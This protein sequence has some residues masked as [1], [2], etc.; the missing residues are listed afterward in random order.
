MVGVLLFIDEP[1]ASIKDSTNDF[2]T[3]GGSMS[4]LIIDPKELSIDDNTDGSI[5]AALIIGD[6]TGNDDDGCIN[7]LSILLDCGP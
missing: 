6:P 2:G 3:L 7:G 1:A 4:D 5:P